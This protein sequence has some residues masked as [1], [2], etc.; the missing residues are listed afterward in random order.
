MRFVRASDVKEKT[1]GDDVALYVGANRSIHVLNPT[2]RFVWGLLQE[3]LT[4]DELLY[5]MTETFDAG[6][7]TLRDDL[8]QTVEHGIAIGIFERLDEPA[9][10]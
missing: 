8:R 7:D 10:S 4:F 2:A 9:L 3:P 1:V 5:I 6:G